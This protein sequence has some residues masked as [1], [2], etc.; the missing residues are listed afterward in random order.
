MIYSPKQLANLLLLMRQ[1][2]GMTQADVA[3]KVGIKQATVS[4]FENNPDK[5]K[6]STMFKIVQALNLSVVVNDSIKTL[7][8]DD[9]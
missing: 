6:L 1:K 8:D 4:N 5:T 2:Q 9:W 7:N 3:I